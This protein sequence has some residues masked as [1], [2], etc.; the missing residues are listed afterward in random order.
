MR[1][2]EMGD[3][4]AEGAGLVI[5]ALFGTGL[6]RGIGGRAAALV[7]WINGRREAGARVLAVDVPSGLDA[8]SGEPVGGVCVEADA[9]VTLAAVKPGL[10][11]LGAQR[12]VGDLSVGAIGVPLGLLGELGRAWVPRTRGADGDSGDGNG[13]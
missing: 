11:R 3:A 8:D 1:F 9:T 5:D 13:G 4:A 10:T 2:V 7:G 12:F 6:S